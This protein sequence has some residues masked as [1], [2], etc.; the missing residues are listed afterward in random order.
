MLPSKWPSPVGLPVS[1][2][3]S[4]DSSPSSLS[5]REAQLRVAWTRAMQWGYRG[6]I[7]AALTY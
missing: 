2:S 6:A 4:S 7:V 3:M 5:G 1:M